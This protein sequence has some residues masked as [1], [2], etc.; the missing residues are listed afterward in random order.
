VALV[1]SL[2]TLAIADPGDTEL[3]SKSADTGEAVRSGGGV[4]SDDGRHVVFESD[5][6]VAEGGHDGGIFALDRVLQTT[7]WLTAGGD[8][9]V[10][11][12]GR[13]VVYTLA[14]STTFRANVWL[15]DRDTGIGVR[16]AE[17]ERGQAS[18]GGRFIAFDSGA[19]NLVAGDTNRMTDVFVR[20][21]QSGVTERVSV[22]PSGRQGN[23]HSFSSRISADG[24]YVAFHSV[25]SN[26]VSGDTNGTGDVF[27]HDRSTHVTERVSV[28]TGGV[29]ANGRAVSLAMSGDG[30]FVA[31]GSQATN[32]VSG[33]TNGVEDAFV[34]DRATGITER[35]SVNAAGTQGNGDSYPVDVSAN[36]RYVA[37]LSG[38]SNLVAND[39]NAFSDVFVYDRETR[40]LERA[41]VS[42]EGLPDRGESL[43]ASVA[44]DGT[45]VFLT[46]AAL[47]A[48]DKN[49]AANYA[50]LDLYLHE[51][52][53]ASQPSFSLRPGS[54]DFGRQAL[55]TNATRSFT[56]INT[57]SAAVPIQSIAVRGTDASMFRY[58]SCCGSSLPVGA[59][60]RIEI[61]FRPVSVGG[62]S[63]T[64]KVVAAGVQR[65]RA[66]SGT[67]ARAALTVSPASI[68]FGSVTVGSTS[69]A[70][71]VRIENTGSVVLPLRSISLQGIN[72]GQFRKTS[73]CPTQVGVG[74]SCTVSVWFKPTSKGEKSA[75]LVIDPGGGAK[76]NTVVLSGSGT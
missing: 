30:R 34:H 19:S 48:S 67:G 72:P 2:P 65:Y 25:A 69:P 26:L 33:D 10:T 49:T 59:S 54:M 14:D 50:D 16:I 7:Q 35:I 36:G 57:G 63:A 46:T 3:I 52:G 62:K 45:V 31:F 71:V 41:S 60:C 66:L 53:A 24:R 1:L 12:D 56:L 18:T 43:L 58:S 29:Q 8:P 37:F 5:G 4:I 23:E 68:S 75:T 61:T 73:N 44:D 13:H 76:T 21:R 6:S 70:R 38:A 51:S 28:G 74:A 32:L 20:D 11:V 39:T 47:V 22:G 15:L 64:L 27:V 9:S 17:G 40:T 42:S 55:F